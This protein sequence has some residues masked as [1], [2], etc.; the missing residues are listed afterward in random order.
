MIR[1]RISFLLLVLLAAAFSTGCETGFV[2][3]AARTSL[4]SFV[5]DVVSTGANEAI[6]P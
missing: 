1:P 6:G 3:E 4:A 5:I 2:T